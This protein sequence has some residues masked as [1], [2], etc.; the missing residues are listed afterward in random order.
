MKRNI[1]LVAIVCLTVNSSA[2]AQ[3]FE[4]GIKAG[5]ELQKI[6]GAKFA[7]GF[8]FGYHVGACA[9]IP[10]TKRWALQPELYYSSATA[11]KANDISA[12]YDTLLNIGDIKKIKFDYINI[13]L[14]LSYKPGKTFALQAGPKYSI[15]SKSNLTVLD[16]AKNAVNNGDFS[17]VAGIQLYF[18]KIRVYGRYEVGLSNV[19]DAIDQEKWR[20]QSVHL[21]ASLKLL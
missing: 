5:A 20:R 18:K 15:L 3:E 19:N 4:F 1:L 2:F 17:M 16:N 21:G 11:N 9:S 6:D 8:A 14:L 10:L 13:P 7:N 12:V